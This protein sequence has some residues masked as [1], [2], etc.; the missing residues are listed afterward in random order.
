MIK[1]PLVDKYQL[2]DLLEYSISTLKGSR[3]DLLIGFLKQ[4]IILAGYIMP[5]NQ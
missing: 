1:G 3:S 5:R 4:E 2:V